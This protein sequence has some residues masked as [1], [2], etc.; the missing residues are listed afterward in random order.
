MDSP[1]M[2]RLPLNG[3]VC[4]PVS[5][6]GGNS[7]VRKV[8]HLLRESTGSSAIQSVN[9]VARAPVGMTRV[10]C[11]SAKNSSTAAWLS[12]PEGCTEPTPSSR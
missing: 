11:S 9:I 12:H 4:A 7:S 2:P 8:R 6:S 5:S 3:R 1:A 10:T